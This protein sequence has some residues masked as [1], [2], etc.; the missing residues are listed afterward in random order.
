MIN[1]TIIINPVEPSFL[2]LRSPLGI[3]LDLGLTF[4][5]QDGEPVDPGTLMPQLALLPRS[6]GGVFAYDCVTTGAGDGLANVTVPGNALIDVSGYS[7]ELY[8]RREADNPV[9][10]PV[11]TALIAKGVLRLEGSAYQ[12]SGPLGMI[13]V[14]T[15]V[16]PPGPPGPEGPTGE[17]GSMWFTGNGP[18]ATTVGTEDKITG[19]MYLDNGL[20]PTMDGAG[21]VWR[22]NGDTWVLGVF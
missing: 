17:R 19:D 8:S 2:S 14:P 3:A 5:A 9:N 10:P 20:P 22:F 21:D 6:A 18:P 13:T 15:I 11:P 7:V 16:G 12:Q 1:R 4:R